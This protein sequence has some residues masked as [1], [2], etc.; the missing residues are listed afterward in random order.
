[1]NAILGAEFST[2][3]EDVLIRGREVL[4]PSRQDMLTEGYLP[5]P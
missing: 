4:E 5:R 1:M 2:R 3:I